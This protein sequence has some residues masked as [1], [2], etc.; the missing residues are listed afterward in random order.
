MVAVPVSHMSGEMLGMLWVAVLAVTRNG[1]RGGGDGN[2]CANGGL[3]FGGGVAAGMGCTG[4]ARRVDVCFGGRV[5]R[6]A[7]GDNRDV[8]SGVAA[9]EG[10]SCCPMCWNWPRWLML[11]S[12]V[13][14]ATLVVVGR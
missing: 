12:C 3:G 7:G 11:P 5:R 9:G 8:V 10:G 6:G 13:V 1:C 4:V 14:L 2:V